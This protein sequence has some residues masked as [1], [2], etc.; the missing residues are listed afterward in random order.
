MYVI[1]GESV[2]V[3]KDHCVS[4]DGAYNLR[5]Y[6]S[7]GRELSVSRLDRNRWKLSHMY[8]RH[9]TFLR[10]VDKYG[11]KTIKISPYRV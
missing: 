7:L 8:Q 1:Q 6:D 9:V 5:Q 10:V 4:I 2:S 3:D 11:E